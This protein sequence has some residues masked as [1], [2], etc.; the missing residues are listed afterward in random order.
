MSSM[1]AC[2]PRRVRGL[3]HASATVKACVWQRPDRA[4]PICVGSTDTWAS[5]PARRRSAAAR[6]LGRDILCDEFR[7]VDVFAEIEERAV[8]GALGAQRRRALDALLGGDAASMARCQR[9]GGARL[10]DRR[11]ECV[12][13]RQ[14]DHASLQARRIIHPPP[15][16]DA[17]RNEIAEQLAIIVALAGRLDHHQRHQFLLRRDPERRAG[18]A[19]Q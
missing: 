9:R 14:R 2:I 7:A 6:K 18:N 13:S 11:L 19:A 12:R 15:L 4:S 3:R 10:L 16:G 1:S 17:R 5:S 8:D